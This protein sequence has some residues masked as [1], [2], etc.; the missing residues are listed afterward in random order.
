MLVLQLIEIILYILAFVYRKEIQRS[1]ENP[2]LVEILNARKQ[3]KIST[4]TGF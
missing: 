2:S 3:R 1:P 4:R